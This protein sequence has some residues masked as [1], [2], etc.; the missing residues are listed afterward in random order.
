MYGPRARVTMFLSRY[1]YPVRTTF[2]HASR[3][4]M[5]EFREEWLGH[6]RTAFTRRSISTWV[7]IEALVGVVLL[8]GSVLAI[9]FV[10]VALPIIAILYC[11]GLVR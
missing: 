8:P 4:A 11:V 6:I 3:A 7:R 5:R 10:Y 2:W 9:L 1:G